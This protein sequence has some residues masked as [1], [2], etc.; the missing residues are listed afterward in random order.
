MS[1]YKREKTLL[2]LRELAAL[3]YKYE[4]KLELS[5]YDYHEG[6][7]DVI[8]K[9]ESLNTGEDLVTLI[10]SQNTPSQIDGNDVIELIDR[11][12]EKLNETN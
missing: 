4:A 9:D 1:E 8:I 10:E 11:L 5:A 12:K 6:D 3:M 2:F 7:L